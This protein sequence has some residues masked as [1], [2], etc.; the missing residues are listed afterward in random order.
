MPQR[1]T[2]AI[3]W[4]GG[5][6]SCMKTDARPRGIMD[7]LWRERA[8]F[9]VLA[10]AILLGNLIHPLAEARAANSADAWVICS[11]YGTVRDPAAPVT[12]GAADDCPMCIT[13]HGSCS[14][15]ALADNGAVL[16]HETA[17]TNRLVAT[18]AG[19]S[20]SA[21]ASPSPAIRAP[22]AFS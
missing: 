9:C 13:G 10:L 7:G 19:R 21:P 1:F 12:P 17:R 6:V 16:A 8:A 3:R 11:S 22:P 2:L 14:L 4:L 20:T 5:Y 18:D 15:A